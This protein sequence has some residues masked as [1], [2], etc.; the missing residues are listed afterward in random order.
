M[1]ANAFT[2]LFMSL[3]GG[4]IITALAYREKRHQFEPKP[5]LRV[6]LKAGSISFGVLLVLCSIGAAVI[7]WNW[8]P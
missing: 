2:V 1:L 8:E 4:I 3:I 6:A 5:S 7:M